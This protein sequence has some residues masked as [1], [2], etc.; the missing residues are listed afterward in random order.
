MA[1]NRSVTVITAIKNLPMSFFRPTQDRL[2]TSKAWKEWL[3]ETER[4]FCYFRVKSPKDK[5]D[6]LLIYGGRE[7]VHLEK[8]A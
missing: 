5:K 8:T 7:I 2:S 4:E 3:E 1:Q 6:A